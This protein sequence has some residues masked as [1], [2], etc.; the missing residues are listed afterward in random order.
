MPLKKIPIK[1]GFNKQD[2]A[3]A[4]ESQW[5]DGDFVRFRYG[6]PEKI[7][8]W[9][10]LVDN[11]LAGPARDQLTWTDLEGRKYAAIGTSKLLVVYYEG[12]F[13]DITPFD[14]ALTSCTLTSTT[15][16]ATVTVNK[17][18]HDL[19]VGDYFKFTSVSLPGGGVTTFTNANFTT[20]VFEIITVP[21]ADTFT[22]TMPVQEAGTGMT[23]QG[24]MTVS[25]Y[26][27]IGNPFQ[28][29]G[30]GWGTGTYGGTVNDVFTTLNE[31]LDS[32]ETDVTLTSVSGFPASGTVK[33]DNELISYTSIVGNDLTGC[34]R[35]AEGT[36][37]ASHSNGATVYDATS[38]IGWGEASSATT[39]KLA[40]GTWSLDNYGQILI[41][42]IGNGKTYT[43]DPSAATPF[44]TRAAVMS[45]AP[46]ASIMTIVSDRDRHV[47]HL[48]TEET[49]GSP[50]TQDPMLIR[51]SNQEDFNTYAPTSTN[52][53]GSFRLD[54]GNT[55]IGAIQGKDYI[56]VLT[57]A[58]AYVI[59]FVGSPFTFSLQQV[60]TNCGCIGQHAIVYIQG[61]VFWM[62]YGGGF[63]V[64]DGTVKQLPSLVEDFVFTTK[65]G[66]PGINYAAGG[67]VYASHNSL[68]N[69]VIWFYPTNNSAQINRSVV[70]NYNEQVWTTMSLARTTYEDAI[71]YDV[72]YATQY[73]TTATPTFPTINGVTNTFGGTDYYEHEVGTNQ[74]DYYGNETAIPAYIR[75]G[76]FD[77]D[78][79]G[80]GEYIMRVKRFVPDFKVLEGNAKVT[81][82]LRDYPADT[83]VSSQLGPY[84]INSS[85]EKI[86][87]RAR[88]RLMSI[89]IENDAVNETWR[90]GLFRVD[91]YPDGRR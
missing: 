58:A 56:L 60:G 69:E 32:S 88:N 16:S 29:Y 74:S 6:N 2:T 28:T 17:T 7:G 34:T 76:D 62:G 86:D 23:A 18:L 78:V 21:T 57:D 40:A 82:F 81:L 12:A 64:Y 83:A 52:T 1:A 50:T 9:Q 89:K 46:T 33:I 25:P 73:S 54:T 19:E 65:G 79:D 59:K 27:N 63:F 91:V 80:D 43:W 5:I 90:Y 8:G 42:T 37:A 35:G 11:T 36:T 72:P 48:G 26:V 49:I 55:I 47:F 51:F 68:F 53:A 77:L 67:L 31:T 10:E 4:A 84:I 24:T 22:I 87:T 15:G 38:F 61:A 3:T 39:L 30:F 70:Y 44:E 45:G 41:A 71:V 20:N 13:Y 66:N 14:T 75:S 85:T